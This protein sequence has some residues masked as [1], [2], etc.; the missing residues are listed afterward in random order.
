MIISFMKYRI[1]KCGLLYFLFFL[2]F[3][4]GLFV[5]LSTLRVCARYEKIISFLILLRRDYTML[6]C[7]MNGNSSEKCH[8]RLSYRS[9]HRSAT[10]IL[11][12]R[13]PH[14]VG[15]SFRKNLDDEKLW[16]HTV[17][18]RAKLFSFSLF[19]SLCKFK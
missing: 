2:S 19:L 16:N 5:I 9:L 11:G 3:A 8:F 14:S 1:Q 17:F 13:V 18:S 12:N 6:L 4:S 10:R 15:N 7:R